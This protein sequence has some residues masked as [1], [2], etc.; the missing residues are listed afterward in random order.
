MSDQ[1][2][3]IVNADE[4]G[5]S[6]EVNHGIIEAH[7]HS[8]VTGASLVVRWPAAAAAAACARAHSSMGPGLHRRH[9]RVDRP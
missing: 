6:L 5:L 4:F 3:L 7:E 9:W 1:R 8:I 2:Y